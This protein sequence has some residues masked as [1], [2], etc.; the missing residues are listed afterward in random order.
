MTIERNYICNFC[1]DRI[2]PVDDKTGIG[3][4][5]VGADGDF[6]LE[7]KMM[8]DTENHI[9]ARCYRSV[10]RLYVSEHPGE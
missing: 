1:R 4:R 2:T 9:C 7:R 10:G 5:W 3:V 6:K 8:V